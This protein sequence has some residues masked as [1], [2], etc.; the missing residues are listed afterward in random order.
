MKWDERLNQPSVEANEE[1]LKEAY[2][3]LGQLSTL[4][5]EMEEEV[6]EIV[7]GLISED[8]IISSYL[9]D[10]NFLEK[11][12]QLLEKLNEYKEFEVD[13]VKEV[14]RSIYA[15]KEKRNELIHGVW[16]V[17]IIK[18]DSSPVIFVGSHRM[19]RP[20][21]II[22]GKKGWASR[23]YKS[24]SFTEISKTIGE[25]KAIIVNLKELTENL[26]N[27]S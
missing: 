26:K 2:H 27:I 21:T 4:F 19:M 17:R 9:I 18:S 16:S 8:W 14:V 15:V 24:Y 10:R 25:I 5:A 6:H 22:K 13:K 3:K 11:N 20:D 12:L 1:V 23:T 7:S